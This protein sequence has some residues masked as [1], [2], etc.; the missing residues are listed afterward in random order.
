VVGTTVSKL[1][2]DRNP[3]GLW[4][5]WSAGILQASDSYSGPYTDVNGAA[6]PFSASASETARFYRLRK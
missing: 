4:L 5:S 2:F 1:T 3:A 6:S